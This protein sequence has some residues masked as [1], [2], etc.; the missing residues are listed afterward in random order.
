M[1][2]CGFTYRADSGTPKFE[3]S[4]QPAVPMTLEFGLGATVG[5]PRGKRPVNH[6]KSR[7]SRALALQPK[8]KTSFA[9]TPCLVDVP[10]PE[11]TI[12][13]KTRPSRLHENLDIRQQTTL[14]AETKIRLDV[15]LP[16]SVS[17]RRGINEKDNLCLS[18]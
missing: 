2:K 13:S 18:Q 5:T 8:D 15:P 7:V 1:Q 17:A 3:L 12:N 11:E 10:A 16:T 14:A 6:P 9:A 4:S